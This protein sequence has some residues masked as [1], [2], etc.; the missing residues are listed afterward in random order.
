MRKEG[1]GITVPHSDALEFCLPHNSAVCM[2]VA[3]TLC[4]RCS[5]YPTYPP[6]ESAIN[7]MHHANRQALSTLG[8]GLLTVKTPLQIAAS[9]GHTDVVAA[10]LEA[11]AVVETC[12]DED[13]HLSE[14]RVELL[15]VIVSQP[16]QSIPG[17]RKVRVCCARGVYLQRAKLNSLG[18]RRS[19]RPALGHAFG[20]CCREGARGDGRRADGGEIIRDCPRLPEALRGCRGVPKTART[21]PN[22]LACDAVSFAIVLLWQP[23]LGGGRALDSRLARPEHAAHAHGGLA[24]RLAHSVDVEMQMQEPLQ[25]SIPGWAPLSRV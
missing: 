9:K 13:G 23:L 18:G 17:G 1:C 16:P 6:P 11:A 21:L 12:M 14:G 8:A 7:H 22:I 4:S 3:D 15:V 25:P 5:G 20:R 2:A 19:E 10:L 24:A